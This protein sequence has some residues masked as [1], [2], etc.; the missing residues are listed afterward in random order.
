MVSSKSNTSKK[1][2]GKA[3]TA[4]Y[5]FY[6]TRSGYNFVSYDSFAKRHLLLRMVIGHEGEEL[7]EED[8]KGI[9]GL[10]NS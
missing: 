3:A 7:E 10:A 6:E 9:I 8:D 1:G 5:A 2:S 4:G